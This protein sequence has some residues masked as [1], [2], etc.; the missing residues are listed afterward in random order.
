MFS[1]QL[2]FDWV[3]ANVIPVHKMS[4]IRVYLPTTDLSHSLLLLSKFWKDLFV[5]VWFL[6]W[7]TVV[8]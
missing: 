2:P 1:G 4:D 7:R 8:D 6:F 3:S 5:I